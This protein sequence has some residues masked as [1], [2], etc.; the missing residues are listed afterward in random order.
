MQ[1]DASIGPSRS[2][3]YFPD[4]LCSGSCRKSSFFHAL[5]ENCHAPHIQY[6]AALLNFLL[7]LTSF[8][9]LRAVRREGILT[10]TNDHVKTFRKKKWLLLYT[11]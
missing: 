1:N 7:T 11:R 8:R 3:S 9:S 4:W 5:L 2:N 6:L 10:K